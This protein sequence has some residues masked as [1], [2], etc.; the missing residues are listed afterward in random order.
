MALAGAQEVTISI[1]DHHIFRAISLP[2]DGP[3]LSKALNLKIRNCEL[4]DTSSNWFSSRNN[5]RSWERTLSSVFINSFKSHS[6]NL[7][8]FIIGKKN[9]Q[10]KI[11]RVKL[12]SD[13]FDNFF[14]SNLIIYW[15]IQHF[16]TFS[17]DMCLKTHGVGLK[18]GVKITQLR[19]T[20]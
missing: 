5:T 6:L 2:Y 8:A 20:P 18:S 16:L 12:C 19:F 15:Y 10:L 14:P 13:I 1:P 7:I 11:L 9:P 3:S 17:E 4:L